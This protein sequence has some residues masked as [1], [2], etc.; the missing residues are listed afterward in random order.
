MSLYSNVKFTHGNRHAAGWK[1]MTLMNVK[2]M[3]FLDLNSCCIQRCFSI[4]MFPPLNEMIIL[5][6]ITTSAVF[7]FLC[8]IKSCFRQFLNAAMTAPCYYTSS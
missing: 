3:V 5:K 8:E 4:L 7:N 1:A 2:Y 6:D